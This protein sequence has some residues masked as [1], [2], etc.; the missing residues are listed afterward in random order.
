M[1]TDNN[2]GV[3]GLCR[4]VSVP[5]RDWRGTRS[6][7]PGGNPKRKTHGEDQLVDSRSAQ[8]IRWYIFEHLGNDGNT[9]QFV[10]DFVIV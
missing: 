6:V 3:L 10:S 8:E 9:A 4:N 7:F 1:D 5:F 2:S